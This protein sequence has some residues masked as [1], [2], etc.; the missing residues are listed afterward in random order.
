MVSVI[1]KG[2]NESFVD[3]QHPSSHRILVFSKYNNSDCR[4]V[5]K[6]IENEVLLCVHM[7][8]ANNDVGSHHTIV[9]LHQRRK[10][11]TWQK[12]ICK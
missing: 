2:H 10:P 8:L 4:K 12:I 6:S 5:S 11:F 9:V 3:Y 7:P 1:S